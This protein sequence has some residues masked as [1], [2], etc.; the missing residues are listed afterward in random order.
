MDAV[1][2]CEACFCSFKTFDSRSQKDNDGETNPFSYSKVESVR[3]EDELAMGR[4]G[5]SS[6]SG[7]QCGM[8]ERVAEILWKDMDFT[9]P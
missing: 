6:G 8:L 7:L 1:T 3:C 5:Q 4:R 9:G 2:Y